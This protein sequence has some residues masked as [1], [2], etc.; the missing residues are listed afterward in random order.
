MASGR[1]R[2]MMHVLGTVIPFFRTI[3]R[4]VPSPFQ[5][6]A[7]ALALLGGIS[8]AGYNFAPVVR[9]GLLEWF[10]PRVIIGVLPG[11]DTPF[12]RRD[13]LYE[14]SFNE[15][16]ATRVTRG[17]HVKALVTDTPAP[18]IISPF[19]CERESF[20]DLYK[21]SVMMHNQGDRTAEGYQMSVTFSGVDEKSQDPNVRI[22]HVDTDGLNVPY[23]YQQYGPIARPS[24]LEPRPQEK[25]T[26]PPTTNLLT[27]QT[28]ARLGLTRDFAMV[29]GALPAHVFQVADFVIKV[30]CDTH[31]FVTL[32]HVDCKD[33][34]LAFRTKSLAQLVRV[35]DCA[36][37]LLLTHEAAW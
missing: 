3:R 21:L 13:L 19:R 14:I 20:R 29:A 1:M 5:G 26:M 10:G 4:H 8:Y 9:H 15:T 31:R 11:D 12:G 17:D 35:P 27:R 22:V 2:Q 7:V 32:F 25:T 33:C 37:A 36:E 24:C 18:V 23:V 30:P 6:L 34:Q 16:L 28:Y